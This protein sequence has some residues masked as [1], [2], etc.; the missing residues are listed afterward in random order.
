M[1]RFLPFRARKR[2]APFARRIDRLEWPLILLLLAPAAALWIF[3]EIADEV[4]EGTTASFD[5]TVLLAF[6][7]AGALDDPI[8]PQWFEEMV[9]DFTALGGT[10][11]LTLVTVLVAGYLLVTRASHSALAIVV[12]VATGILLS[13][14]TKMGFD[15]PR[16]DLVPHGSYVVT[17]SFP[18]GHSMMSAVVYLTLGA[19]LARVQ[20][21]WAGRVYVL[22]AAIVIVVLVGVSRVYLGVHWPTD[23]LA[24]WAVGA[25]WAL[26]WWSATL[27]L[28]NRGAVETPS[29]PGAG[30]I[31]G[32]P[33]EERATNRA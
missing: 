32:H 3:V 16:P 33:G 7:T 10:G 25:G 31:G 6:R 22:A 2:L 19:M 11:V 17:A 29:L 23:V 1:L 18:S 8:G 12:A 20:A 24:G 14:L 4:V 21:G 13:T 5:R 27:W 30:E 9:R 28:Q 15:R 26:M